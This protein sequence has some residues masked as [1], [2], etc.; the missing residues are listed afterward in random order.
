MKCHM[1]GRKKR[2]NT[3]FPGM[4]TAGILGKETTVKNSFNGSKN[5]TRK[6][7]K[8]GGRGRSSLLENQKTITRCP[9]CMCIQGS[10][11]THNG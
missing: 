5:P 2:G 6:V 7:R 4:E 11:K 1:I 8:R 10:K 9:L 3:I